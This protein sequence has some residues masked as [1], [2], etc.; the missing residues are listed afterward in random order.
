MS[1]RFRWRRAA[2]AG[3]V[4]LLAGFPLLAAGAIG[5]GGAESFGLNPAPLPDGR[6]ESYFNLA[7]DTRAVGHGHR[8][9]QRHGT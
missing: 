3:L 9:P 5:T 1:R 8:H 4:A 6:A 2:A 7:A